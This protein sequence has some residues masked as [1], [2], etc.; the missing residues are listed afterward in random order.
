MTGKEPSTS[1]HF[2]G[3]KSSKVQVNVDIRLFEVQIDADAL[4]KQM[5]LLRG[6]TLF[7]KFLTAKI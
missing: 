3:V 1:N 6:I 4:E 5:N 7:K 2:G